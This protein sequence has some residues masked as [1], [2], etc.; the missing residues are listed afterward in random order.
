MAPKLTESGSIVF[1][2]QGRPDWEVVEKVDSGLGQVWLGE[3]SLNPSTWIFKFESFV[4]RIFILHLEDSQSAYLPVKSTTNEGI[5][6]EDSFPA[7]RGS[8]HKHDP[9]ISHLYEI[10]QAFI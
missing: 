5:F 8:K 2:L 6:D 4:L 1:T 9:F 7:A 3:H 10:S